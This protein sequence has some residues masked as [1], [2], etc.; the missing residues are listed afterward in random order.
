ML[1]VVA[2]SVEVLIEVGTQPEEAMAQIRGVA[3]LSFV[4][5]EEDEAEAQVAL[6]LALAPVAEV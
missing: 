5:K 1:A 4:I 2:E 3:V 6:M